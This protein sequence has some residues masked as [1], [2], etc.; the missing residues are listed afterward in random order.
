MTRAT[1][2]A[3]GL[4]TGRARGGGGREPR[5]ACGDRIMCRRG[6]ACLLRFCLDVSLYLDTLVSG[7]TR[8]PT[9]DGDGPART[10]PRNIARRRPRTTLRCG[11][12]R[13][14]ASRAGRRHRPA[15]KR[16][17]AWGIVTPLIRLGRLVADAVG[18]VVAGW[19][20]VIAASSLHISS[21]VPEV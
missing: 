12:P 11:W 17:A 9:R 14:H 19:L 1:A 3:P 8:N 4:G 13:S 20:Q 16:E 18:R 7:P 6:S 2:R 10:A 5:A 15:T 21:Q